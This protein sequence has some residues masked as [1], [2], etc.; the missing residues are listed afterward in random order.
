MK[1]ILLALLGMLALSIGGHAQIPSVVLDVRTMAS[2]S[3][4]RNDYK[5]DWGSYDK[6]YERS[7][8][9][10]IS[11]SMLRG[12]PVKL[13]VTTR[14][15][16]KKMSGKDYVTLGRHQ[17]EIVLKAGAPQKWNEESGAIK[18]RDLNLEAIGDRT[19]GGAKISGWVVTVENEVGQILAR[20]TSDPTMPE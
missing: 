9:I 14:W 7:R 11:V 17:Q 1:T 5:T 15:V 16:G 18:A 10:E 4:V 19:V 6:N 20:K 12:E 2:K 13:F 8:V 3:A